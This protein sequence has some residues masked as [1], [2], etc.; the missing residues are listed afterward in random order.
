MSR[1]G[2]LTVRTTDYEIACHKVTS[3]GGFVQQCTRN[4]GTIADRNTA[5][6]GARKSENCP[7]NAPV[8]HVGTH[9][10]TKLTASLMGNIAH[11]FQLFVI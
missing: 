2:C 9:M 6:P 11:I 5:T 3:L 4:S 8:I 10:V 1:R 7:S